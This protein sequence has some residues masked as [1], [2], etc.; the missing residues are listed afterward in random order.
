MQVGWKYRIVPCVFLK[1]HTI[2]NLSKYPC[3][4]PVIR[5]RRLCSPNWTF[6]LPASGC[7]HGVCPQAPPLTGD[8]T[9]APA[10]ISGH[11]DGRHRGHHV[12]QVCVWPDHSPPAAGP[13]VSPECA[14][15]LPPR[16]TAPR[17]RL[18][19]G[20]N[21]AP[22]RPSDARWR[23]SGILANIA[24][25]VVQKRNV[26]ELRVKSVGTEDCGTP[27]KGGSRWCVT[28]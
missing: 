2:C 25:N 16:G 20:Q 5:I 1:K 27:R 22:S 17:R 7:A 24:R 15:W 4:F 11:S 23:P 8:A 21:V 28:S 10:P 9:A 13:S 6:P 18:R 26:G 19:N 3:V 12:R 14:V